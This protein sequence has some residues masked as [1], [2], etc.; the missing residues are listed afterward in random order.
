MKKL[1]IITGLSPLS[2]KDPFPWN[3]FIHPQT[4]SKFGEKL[5]LHTFL[6]IKTEKS[7]IE[8]IVNAFPFEGILENEIYVSKNV[9]SLFNLKLN[10]QIEVEKLENIG[11]VDENNPIKIEGFLK[12][13]Q[14]KS[15]FANINNLLSRRFQNKVLSKNGILFENLFGEEIQFIITKI[16]Q[17]GEENLQKYQYIIAKNIIVETKIAP[18][19]LFELNIAR[20]AYQKQ[21]KNLDMIENFSHLSKPLKKIFKYID[22]KFKG[23]NEEDE[24]YSIINKN[25]QR[26]GAV[27]YGPHGIGKTLLLKIVC[28]ICFLQMNINT[29]KISSHKVIEKR[30]GNEDNINYLEKKI[31]EACEKEPCLIVIDEFDDLLDLKKNQ[32]AFSQL[33]ILIEKNFPNRKLFLL[34]ATRTEPD[35]GIVSNLYKTGR[36][37]D[38]IQI[39]IPN[40]ECRK[41]L[42]KFWI[43][44]EHQKSSLWEIQED[45]N[46]LIEFL[47]TKTRGF[48]P[49]DIVS[50][51]KN[52]HLNCALRNKDDNI[53]SNLKI[54]KGDF[55]QALGEISPS[56]IDPQFQLPG[57]VKDLEKLGGYFEIKK[58][59]KQTILHFLAKTKQSTQKIKKENKTE[60]LQKLVVPSGILLYGPSGCGKTELV[61]STLSEMKIPSL[62]VNS[63][64][65]FSKYV[66]DTESAIRTVFS[67]ARAVSPSVIFLDE[68]DAIGIK[69]QFDQDQKVGIEERA[70]SQLLT[71]MDGVSDRGHLLVI[72]CTN[73]IDLIDE[74]L[75]RPG[76]LEKVV[77]V[78]LPNMEDRSEILDILLKQIHCQATQKEK[79]ETVNL[80]NGWTCSD[81]QTVSQLAV[82][83]ALNID[84]KT[85]KVDFLHFKKAI[86]K[87]LEGLN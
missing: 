12:M 34:A 70:L 58:M 79:T 30:Y 31:Y 62:I 23:N 82:F 20:Y 73:R 28:R 59:L 22:Q 32:F 40:A 33:M 13:N 18:Q 48:T 21:I 17:D 63:T 19:K 44:T 76:R 43:S 87:F 27:I 84:I 57:N 53:K 29:V 26:N 3:T 51:V 66:G 54:E 14:K 49:K 46:M 10:D 67:R 38:E 5:S 50:L 4:L 80:T 25:T 41:K 7:F 37:I 9:I 75:V 60:S 6:K 1:K 86:K 74:A 72:S 24:K 81:L 77:S 16:S 52:A 55:E 47:T 68:I 65:L 11:I 56:E 71:E 61:I 69:R 15:Q 64:E 35:P 78:P 39:H 36:F 83:E 85:E 8:M 2:N 42:L 45:E